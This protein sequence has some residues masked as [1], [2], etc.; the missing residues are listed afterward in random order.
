MAAPPPQW[1]QP[2]RNGPSRRRAT[3]ADRGLPSKKQRAAILMIRGDAVGQFVDPM[4]DHHD[5]VLNSRFRRGVRRTTTPCRRDRDGGRLFQ[6]RRA[7]G[8]S[9]RGGWRPAASGPPDM[10]KIERSPASGRTDAKRR[11]RLSGHD[12]VGRAGRDFPG[13]KQ[14]SS[15]TRGVGVDDMGFGGPGT[16]CD[17]GR[18]VSHLGSGT[19]SRT[20]LHGRPVLREG[21]WGM[22][23]LRKVEQSLL[24]ACARPRIST[25]SPGSDAKAK[26]AVDDRRRIARNRCRDGPEI[27]MG[28]KRR[29]RPAARPRRA[30]GICAEGTGG[31]PSAPSSQ[32]VRHRPLAL[33]LVLPSLTPPPRCRARRAARQGNGDRE[34]EHDGKTGALTSGSQALRRY[35]PMPIVRRRR[36]K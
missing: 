32:D 25:K 19:D 12:L 29:N 11:P 3:K 1:F 35:R 10:S 28:E 33:Q 4:F 18:E 17:L 6:Y 34:D 24:A 30:V 9:N 22:V 7:R 8:A 36:R 21:V 20:P 2:L 14:T 27:E 13:P 16:Q 5:V 15:R 23:P 31:A 26:N